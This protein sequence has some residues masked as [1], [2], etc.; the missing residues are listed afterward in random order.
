[1]NRLK[2]LRNSILKRH[3][4]TENDKFIEFTKKFE[5]F[6]TKVNKTENKDNKDLIEAFERYIENENEHKYRMERM[7]NITQF[8]SVAFC[9]FYM[10]SIFR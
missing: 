4:S 9:V 7:K 10:T 8:G 1:M 5:E 6:S 2:L 3:Y